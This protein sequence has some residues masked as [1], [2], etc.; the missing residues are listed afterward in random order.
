MWLIGF[1]VDEGMPFYDHFTRR[2]TLFVTFEVEFP[3][4]AF[5][6]SESDTIVSLLGQNSEQSAY[7][8]L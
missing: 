7:N 5:S 1:C 8:G 4:K 3:S 2:G 6:P